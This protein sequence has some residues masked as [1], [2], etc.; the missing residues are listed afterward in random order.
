MLYT[1]SKNASYEKFKPKVDLIYSRNTYTYIIHIVVIDY[2]LR[3]H[4]CNKFISFLFLFSFSF[5]YLSY[6][7]WNI[8]N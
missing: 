4:T 8:C 3:L 6:I 1:T 7:F 2:R 5:L